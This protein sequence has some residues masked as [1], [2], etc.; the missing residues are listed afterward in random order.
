MSCECIGLHQVSPDGSF[1]G[2]SSLSR[3]LVKLD[4]RSRQE[5]AY[6]LFADFFPQLV[7]EDLVQTSIQPAFLLVTT[8]REIFRYAL[9]RREQI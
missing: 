3:R 2:A 6:D 1:S 7:P 4:F 8:S 9:Q 5:P